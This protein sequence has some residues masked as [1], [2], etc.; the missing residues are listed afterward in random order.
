MECVRSIINQ[1]KLFKKD[2]M[3]PL[4]IGSRIMIVG[5]TGAG[6]SSICR[7]I[8]LYKKEMF[9]QEEPQK[10][11]FCY[12]IW[13][14][15]YEDILKTFPIVVFKSGLPTV[16]DLKELSGISKKHCL[17]FFDDM[18]HELV[19]DIDIERLITGY[20]H[21]SRITT[22]IMSQNLYYQGKNSKTLNI[23][24]GSFILMSS[25]TDTSQIRNFGRQIMGPG[26]KSRAFWFAYEDTQKKNF[27]YLFVDVTPSGNMKHMLRSFIFPDEGP[28]VI[29]RIK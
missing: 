12:S 29:Y 26:K 11:L 13:Q 16:D 15:L 4:E 21:H 6:K 9:P 2:I 25:R 19:N 28:T 5:S 14:P 23:N 1:C 7:K 3:Y 22:V 20:A 8:I 10:I 27:Q 17:V 24:Q 18:I